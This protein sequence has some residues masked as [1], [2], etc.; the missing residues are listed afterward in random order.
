[1]S[2][3]TPPHALPAF[4][5]LAFRVFLPFGLGY[6]LS[7]LFRTV[8][9]VLGPMLREELGISASS[10]GLVTGA[11]FLA[12]ALVQLP[13][14]M[15]LDRYGPRRT[16]AVLLSVTALGALLFSLGGDTLSLALARAVIGIGVSGCL[17]A[18]FKAFAL[19]FD[20]GRLPLVNGLVMA[21]GS[22][23]VIAASTPVQV[24][25]TALGWRE[26]FHILAATSIAVAVVIVLVVPEKHVEG[27][28]RTFAD[29]VAGLKV[30]FTAPVFWSIAPLLATAQAAWLSIQALW[31]GPWL[32]DTAGLD[33]AAAADALLLGGVGGATGYILLGGLTERLGRLGTPVGAVAGTAIVLFIAVQALL[34][35]GSALPPWMLTFAFAFFGGGATLF[36]AGLTQRFPVAL[37]GRVNTSLALFVFSLA[38]ALQVLTG[39]VLDLFPDGRG[40]YTG[41]G[42]LVAFGGWALVQVACFVWFLVRYPRSRPT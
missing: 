3:Q 13:L 37:A 32:R 1:M 33:A 38:F 4:P 8:N 12:F 42:Y 41:T 5:F 25:A 16:Q 18:S 27:E 6:F 29:Q 20:K 10:L 40:G 2:F 36:Y 34:A 23:G 26:V 28:P 11:F 9:A 39:L 31:L 21:C 24:L 14:G 17:L 19:W 15:A 35:L 30:I 22:L 7:Q